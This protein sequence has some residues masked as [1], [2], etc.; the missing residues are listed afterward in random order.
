[1]RRKSY[2]FIAD[3]SSVVLEYH[4]IYKDIIV[5]EAYL[6]LFLQ[7]HTHTQTLTPTPFD[8]AYPE[9]RS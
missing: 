2:I 1:M 5:Q 8:T 6:I 4:E 7:T 9:W 3:C